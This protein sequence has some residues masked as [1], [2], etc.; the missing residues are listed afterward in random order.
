MATFGLGCFWGAEKLFWNLPGVYSTQVGYAGGPT[1]NP[2]YKEVCSGKTGHTEVVRVVFDPKKITYETLLRAFWEKSR[3]DARNATRQRR[4][5]AIPVGH[6]YVRR[7]TETCCRRVTS[8]VRES[9]RRSEARQHHDR[10]SRALQNFIMRRITT[11]STSQETR[12]AIAASAARECLAPYPS[13]L[14]TAKTARENVSHAIARKGLISAEF[15]ATV[16]KNGGLTIGRSITSRCVARPSEFAEILREL[17]LRIQRARVSAGLT[18][19]QAAS[20]SAIDYKRWQRLEEGSVNPTVK[21]LHRVAAA[22]DVPFW[23]LFA[24]MQRRR[25]SY[26]NLPRSSGKMPTSGRAPHSSGEIP[27]VRVSN[28]PP[29]KRAKNRE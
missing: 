21:T 15:A 8:S 3:S 29:S 13:D 16:L 14:A 9:A 6:L 17:G 22:L 26:D 4:R 11:S 27:A 19:E 25:G 20:D 5:D 24:P 12:E 7:R 18:Q 1:P 28:P 2:T 23:E 10:K